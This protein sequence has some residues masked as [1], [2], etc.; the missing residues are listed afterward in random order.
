MAKDQINKELENLTSS[1]FLDIGTVEAL[2]AKEIN[3]RGLTLAEGIVAIN[4][5]HKTEIKDDKPHLVVSGFRV[6]IKSEPWYT[7]R[8]GNE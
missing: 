6:S 1:I 2:I 5:T 8:A 7:V 3:A 4:P